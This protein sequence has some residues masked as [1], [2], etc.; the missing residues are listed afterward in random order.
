[1][2]DH[3]KVPLS[4]IKQ[5][6]IIRRN[7]WISAGFLS[8]ILE[9]CTLGKEP[10]EMACGKEETEGF[11]KWGFHQNFKGFRGDLGGFGG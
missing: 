2:A 9:H 1:M 8:S 7:L 4:S 10:R 6:T 3:K 5:L 11:L